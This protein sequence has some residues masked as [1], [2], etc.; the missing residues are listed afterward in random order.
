[1]LSFFL[2][3]SR[4]LLFYDQG[5]GSFEESYSSFLSMDHPEGW[6]AKNEQSEEGRPHLARK[7]ET[8]KYLSKSQLEDPNQN[9]TNP[10]L[11]HLKEQFY[12]R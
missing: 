3:Q 8:A 6:D 12:E 4:S 7:H 5:A 1:M 11:A 2:V 9:Q 10:T